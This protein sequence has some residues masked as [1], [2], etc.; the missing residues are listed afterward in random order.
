MV[1]MHKIDVCSHGCVTL[2][3]PNHGQFSEIWL[4]STSARENLM[5][6]LFEHLI[7]CFQLK[8]RKVNGVSTQEGN[9]ATEGL[10]AF[11]TH[12]F[13][14]LL[15]TNMIDNIVAPPTSC[16]CTVTPSMK[17]HDKST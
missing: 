13:A 2:L 3:L 10:R 1:N 16:S 14:V 9:E 11:L 6:D 12:P 17:H 4:D 7:V 5:V 15:E 8:T